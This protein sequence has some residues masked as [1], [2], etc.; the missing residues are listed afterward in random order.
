MCSNT[1]RLSKYRLNVICFGKTIFHFKQL[2]YQHEVTKNDE[3]F[4]PDTELGAGRMVS[5]SLL[6]TMLGSLCLGFC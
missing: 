1:I 6:H 3:V 5:V 2:D 4:S